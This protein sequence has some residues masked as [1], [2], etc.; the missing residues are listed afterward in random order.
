MPSA[1]ARRISPT[2]LLRARINAGK[3][4]FFDMHLSLMPQAVRYGFLGPVHWAV[5]E[6]SDSPAA[7][8]SC[9]PLGRRRADLSARGREDTHRAELT[10]PPTLLGMHDIYEPEDPPARREIP[11][12]APP[13]ASARPS[14]KSIRQDRRRRRNRPDR[15]DRR[16]RRA[17]AR[18]PRKS[19]RTSPSFW[20]AKSRR[21]DS[22]SRSCPFNRASAISPTPSWARWES[23]PKF[24]ALRCTPRFFR[25]PSSA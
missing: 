5:V 15:R 22:P 6:A 21:P 17:H 9:S 11:I 23:I 1:S 4:R 19:A 10:H 18:S 13:T 20:P 12:Y 14:I 3:T 16:L 7:A 24:P 8:A 2:R 25:T